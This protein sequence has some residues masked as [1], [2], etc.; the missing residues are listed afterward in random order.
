MA[1]RR[2]SFVAAS[3]VAYCCTASIVFRA[4]TRC[5]LAFDRPSYRALEGWL[6]DLTEDTLRAVATV[7]IQAMI[8]SFRYEAFRDIFHVAIHTLYHETFCESASKKSLDDVAVFT[9]HACAPSRSLG[10]LLWRVSPVETNGPSLRSFFFPPNATTKKMYNF[11]SFNFFFFRGVR[12]RI[13]WWASCFLASGSLQALPRLCHL[14]LR[15]CHSCVP[16]I[17]L[18]HAHA[19]LSP[20][21]SCI[22]PGKRCSACSLS[23]ISW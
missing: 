23:D 11:G 2:P 3:D 21:F 13:I 4:V 15:V 17:V 6:A 1:A 5:W 10:P 16:A 14:L 20:V 19:Y 8:A 9:A 18:C 12:A 22:L 7:T